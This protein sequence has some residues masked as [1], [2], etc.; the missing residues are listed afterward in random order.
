MTTVLVL[1]ASGFLGRHVVLALE[2]H[3]TSLR[4]LTS[5]REVCDLVRDPVA[6]LEQTLSDM[7][8][9]VV[10]NCTGRLDGSA[11]E[12]VE[13]NTLTTAKLLDALATVPARLVRIG[14]AGEYGVVPVGSRVHEEVSAA[15]VGAYGASHLA[16]TLLIEQARRAGRVDAVSL[17][18][19]NPIGT[20]L[21]GDTVLGKAARRLRDALVAPDGRDSPVRLGNMDAYR[22][23]VD[24]RDVADAVVAAVI[25]PPPWGTIN[26][27]SGRATRVREAVRVL[28]DLAGYRGDIVEAPVTL[29]RSSGVR[30][31]Q[32]D[33]TR[34]R[35]SLG[36]RPRR[37][38]EESLKEIWSDVAATKLRPT[39]SVGRPDH[40]PL[41]NV[42]T[43]ERV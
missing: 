13:A 33:I 35:D 30:W 18:V 5:G 1:G 39:R 38:L 29:G 10:V 6:R 28:A 3:P 40:R 26:I 43:N 25:S 24:A 31:I 15:P 41:V 7:A 36:W 4:V 34:A 20:G 19:F 16:A 11:S 8:P 21:N 14:S 23:F 2:G 37:G 9:D 32:A 17:R 27:G 22:D 42:T 12:L